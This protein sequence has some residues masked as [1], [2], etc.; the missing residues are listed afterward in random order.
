MKTIK[1]LNLKIIGSDLDAL[2]T[3]TGIIV[4]LI[5]PS[6]VMDPF[7]KRI[8][9]LTRGSLTRLIGSKQFKESDTGK[10]FSI[11]FFHE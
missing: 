3:T 10:L 7:A 5:T 11:N 6:G 2:A 4:V 8:N 9:K 1:P